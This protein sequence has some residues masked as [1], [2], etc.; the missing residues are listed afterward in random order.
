MPRS[1]SQQPKVCMHASD[2]LYRLT[3]R[4]RSSL[5]VPR[6]CS[7]LK[8]MRSRSQE[9]KVCHFVFPGMITFELLDL[10]T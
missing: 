10:L 5:P 2:N 1:K 4:P 9:P 8:V 7:D 6:S 3:Y